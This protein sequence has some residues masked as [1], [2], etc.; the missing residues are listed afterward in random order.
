MAA[1]GR[2]RRSQDD[3]QPQKR[4]AIDPHDERIRDL[5]FIFGIIG[6]GALTFVIGRATAPGSDCCETLVTRDLELILCE[7]RQT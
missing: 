6:I 3:W 2:A 1:R 7:A 4:T 5:G